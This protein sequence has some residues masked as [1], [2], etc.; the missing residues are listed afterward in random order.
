MKWLLK[1]V[2]VVKE[3]PPVAAKFS[4]KRDEALLNFDLC[5]ED[6]LVGSLLSPAIGGGDARGWLGLLDEIWICDI[7]S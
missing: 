3:V 1:V 2:A 5:W 7:T 4:S 6:D